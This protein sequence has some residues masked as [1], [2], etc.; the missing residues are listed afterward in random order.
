M[1]TMVEHDD[2]GVDAE[3]NRM[4][5]GPRGVWRCLKSDPPSQHGPSILLF[6]ML[7]DCGDVYNWSNPVYARLNG[8]KHGYTHWMAVEPHPDDK[9]AYARRNA[10][11]PMT[12]ADYAALSESMKEK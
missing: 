9:A 3:R 7:C 6:P 4:D 5:I 2:G 8:L 1:E 12:D 10:L 11:P